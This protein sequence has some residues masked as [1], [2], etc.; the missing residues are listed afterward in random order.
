MRSIDGHAALVGRGRGRRAPRRLARRGNW[1]RAD[2]LRRRPQPPPT[3][4]RSSS[5]LAA[6]TGRG[7]PTKSSRIIASAS[8]RGPRPCSPA[9]RL[10]EVVPLSP[11]DSSPSKRMK[12]TVGRSSRGS[13]VRASSTT[14]A[15]PP[16][17]SLA[18]TKPGRSW[19]RS[20][21]R[22][23]PSAR[24]AAR[25]D[26]DHV[27]QPAG[28]GLERP[29]GGFCLELPGELL[30]GLRPRRTWT[31][32]HLAHEPRPG[33]LL[34]HAIDDGRGGRSDDRERGQCR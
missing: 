30:R 20:A 10:E 21:P 11:G 31:E 14:S 2:A 33:C 19:C 4:P 23:R 26:A 13:I 6:A 17:P 15:V 28:H 16:A 9:A 7:R 29:A 27:A 34:V 22:R 24:I 12:T 32:L 1:W 25:D 18:P 3:A 5:P 8:R